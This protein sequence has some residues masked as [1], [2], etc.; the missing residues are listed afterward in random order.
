MTKD[1]WAKLMQSMGMP[2]SLSC[3]KRLIKAYSETHRYYHTVAH[4]E[5]ML[6]HFDKVRNLADSPDEVEIA[7]WF[8]DAIYN[9]LSSS[10]EINS[11]QWAKDFLI[12]SGGE[13][14]VAERVYELIMATKHDG[15]IV[16]NDHKL[17]VDIDLTIL[18]ANESVYDEFEAN[19]R[20]EYKLIPSVIF[21]KKRI[22]ILMSFLEEEA[23]YKLDYFKENFEI[24]AR[25]NLNRAISH[26]LK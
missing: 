19:V 8:H 12:S 23:I 20:K 1:R 25:E 9:P 26:L 15:K 22:A 21:R 4:I 11:A 13:A 6:I 18:G 3:Y 17:I 16:E 14:T 24:Q 10:N 2:S 5:A 7:I